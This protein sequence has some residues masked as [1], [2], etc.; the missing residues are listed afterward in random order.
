MEITFEDKI[1]NNLILLNGLIVQASVTSSI[2]E[3]KKKLMMAQH[4]IDNT[5]ALMESD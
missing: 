1:D 4:M 5:L 2:E 3:R